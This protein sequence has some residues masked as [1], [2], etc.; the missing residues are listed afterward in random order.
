M[1][2]ELRKL[3]AERATISSILRSAE[4]TTSDKT[5]LPSLPG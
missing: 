5:A 2:G 4:R 3:A 1:A